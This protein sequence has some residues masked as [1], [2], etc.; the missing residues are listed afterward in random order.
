MLFARSNFLRWYHP[1]KLQIGLNCFQPFGFGYPFANGGDDATVMPDARITKIKTTGFDFVRLVV[2]PEALLTADSASNVTTTQLDSRIAE[3]IAGVARRTGLGLKVMV[4][5][6]FHGTAVSV[7]SGWDFISV[8][9]GGTKATRVGF[10]LARLA[11]AI[12]TATRTSCYPANVCLEIFNEP[13][14]A[15]DVATATYITQLETWWAQV[16]A[17]MPLHTILVGGNNYNAMDGTPAGAASGLTSLTASHFDA[18]TGFVIH[19]YESPAYTHQGVDGTIYQYGHNI[20]WP[21]TANVSEAAV[22][23]AWTAATV[24]EGNHD[25]VTASTALDLVVTQDTFF[26]SIHQFYATYGTRAALATYLAVATGW[27]DSAGI[28]RKRIFNT[29]FGCNFAGSDDTDDASAAA[30]VTA[31]RQNAD[32]AGINCIVIHEMQGSNFGIQ[33]TSTPWAFNSSIQTAL[34]P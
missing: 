17:V 33:N 34:F 32:T 3:V 1:D 25:G 9:D 5:F 8:F 18:N 6:H 13:P 22:K 16:R 2:D 19:N 7:S 24:S 23:S 10:V 20:S 31:V 15:A 21:A 28:S 30:F 11:A 14:P 27:S 12:H 26:S 29:E 4:D